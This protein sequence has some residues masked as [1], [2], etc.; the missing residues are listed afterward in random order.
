LAKER[1]WMELMNIDEGPWTLVNVPGWGGSS[2][3]HWQSLWEADHPSIVRV[4]QASWGFP[5]LQTWVDRLCE[6]VSRQTRP[7]VLVGHSLGVATIAHAAAQGAL[8]SV[9]GAFLVAM[10]DV[11]R[12]GFPPEIKGFSPLPR[13][14]L[15]FPSL[16][17]GSQDDPYIA[18]PV[19]AH[20]AEVFGSRFVDVGRRHHLGDAAGLGEWLE[21]KEM[22][23]GF[24]AGLPGAPAGH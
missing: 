2:P 18:S 6:V 12:T 14:K 4:V 20:W 19:L 13:K 10:P 17:V 22:L 16:M 11:E 9:V 5:V 8:G 1:E 15:P 23:A 7:V 24:L 3:S 21:G